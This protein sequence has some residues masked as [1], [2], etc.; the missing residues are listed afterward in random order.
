[1]LECERTCPVT[2]SVTVAVTSTDGMV[3]QAADTGSVMMPV[4]KAT[5]GRIW[6]VLG[7]PVDVASGT[8]EVARSPP[9]PAVRAAC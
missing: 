3:R 1:M 9:L 7:R 8:S 4:G 2:S 5:L 6:N